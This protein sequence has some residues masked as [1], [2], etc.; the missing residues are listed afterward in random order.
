MSTAASDHGSDPDALREKYRTERDKRFRQ[1][2]N[3]QYVEIKGKF[4][5]YLDDPHV[6]PITR[7]P[8][9]D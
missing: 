7:G 6:A 3:N 9:A 1:D 4:A 5:H 2:G 8:L